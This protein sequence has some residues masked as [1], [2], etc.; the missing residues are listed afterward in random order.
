MKELI[1]TIPVSDYPI[2]VKIYLDLNLIGKLFKIG[3]RIPEVKMELLTKNRGKTRFRIIPNTL[4]DG[5]L[6][7]FFPKN[8]K[9]LE[10]LLKDQ[11]VREQTQE[12]KLFGK[13]LKFYEPTILVEFYETHL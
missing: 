8:L 1:E 11:Q 7:N 4:R 5:L 13:G 2:V 10:A 6:I 9:E 3:F 12:F